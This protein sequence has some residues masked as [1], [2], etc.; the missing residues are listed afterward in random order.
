MEDTIKEYEGKVIEL[1]YDWNCGNKGWCKGIIYEGQCYSVSLRDIDSSKTVIVTRIPKKYVSSVK[2]SRFDNRINHL[3]LK[4][5]EW[6][7]AGA[8]SSE[9]DGLKVEMARPLRE[10]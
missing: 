6:L 7:S 3:E 1:S 8:K 9:I 2:D 4:V 5:I 10:D